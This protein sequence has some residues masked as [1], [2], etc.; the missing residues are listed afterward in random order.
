MQMFFLAGYRINPEYIEEIIIFRGYE[1][2]ILSLCINQY[3]MPM[4]K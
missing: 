2:Y 1:K 4:V 3:L